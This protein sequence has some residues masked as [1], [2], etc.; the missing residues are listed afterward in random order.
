M[1]AMTLL[2]E[3][4]A[5]RPALLRVLL[6]LG[7][8]LSIPLI[9][10]PMPLPAQMVVSFGAV[11]LLLVLSR[12]AGRRWSLLMMAVSALL[13]SRYLWWR[14]TETMGMA[15][16][17]QTLLGIGLLLAE[18][19]AWVVMLLG[20]V[21]SA[22]P[23]G[24]K[25]VPLPAD[26]AA[27][28]HVDV[29]I[30]TYNESLEIVRNTVWAALDMDWP[31]DRLHVHLLDDGDRPEF[32]EFAARCGVNYIARP[33][34]RHAKAGNLNH[35]LAQT[36]APFIAIFDCDHVPNRAFL[37]MTM[38]GFLNEQRLALVQ[39]PHHFY[40]PDPV[41]RNLKPG[42]RLA[43]EGLLFY[44]LVQDGNDLWDSAFFCGSCAVLRREALVDIGGFAV[45][46]VTED[47]H[48]A[49]RLHRHGWTSAYLRLPLA[50]GLATETLSAHL[51]QRA[52]WARG[53][54]QIFRTDNP[55]FGR[56][57][58]WGQ[59]LCYLNAMLHFFFP[60][61]RIVVLTAPLA[62]LVLNINIMV[63]SAV[64]VVGYAGPHL[65]M[66]VATNHRLQG[67]Y[68]SLF[69]GEVYE[70][71]LAFHLLIPTLVTLINPKKGRFNVTD[72]GGL[73]GFGFFDRRSVLPQIVTILL[74]LA[75]YGWGI[76]RAATD[77]LAE[78]ELGVLLINMFWA[79]FNIMILG[80]AAATGLEKRQA[81]RHVRIG[82]RLPLTLHLPD[83]RQVQGVANDISMGGANLC[84]PMKQ[85]PAPAGTE[86]K[87]ELNL[88]GRPLL[89]PAQVM[90]DATN[91]TRLRF[92]D[93][94]EMHL[95]L[96]VLATFGRAD[97]WLDWDQVEEAGP[98]RSLRRILSS[99]I[100]LFAHWLR[101]PTGR[102][103]AAMLAGLGLLT[104][105]AVLPPAALAA[106]AADPLATA[107][108]RQEV[109]PLSGMAP[110][111]ALTLRGVL[112]RRGLDFTVR[113][114]EVV[115]AAA[116]R[117]SLGNSPALLS[118]LSHLQ[119]SVNG[120]MVGNVAFSP[121]TAEGQV[122]EIPIDPMVLR[123]ENRIGLEFVGHYTNGCE[124]P[125]H[126]SLWAMVNANS[127]LRLSL[128]RLALTTD[129]SLLPRPF[130]D[131]HDRRALNLPFVLGA[132]PSDAVLRAAGI[133]ASWFGAA[134]DFRPAHFPAYGDQLPDDH[135]VIVAM[136]Q[137]L[138]PG[139]D[140]GPVE[141]PTIAVIPNPLSP[142]HRLLLVLGRT[143]EE[144]TAAALALALGGAGGLTGE[145]ATV[146]APVPSAR[147]PYDAPR[148]IPTGRSVR[149][150]ELATP[151]QLQGQGLR[152][153]PVRISF[154]MAPDLFVWRGRGVPLTV[155]YRYPG[156]N[157]LDLAQSRLDI[158]LNGVYV[159][160]LKLREDRLT[161][162]FRTEL[163]DDY[164]RRERPVRLPPYLFY[165][166]NRLE[167]F[168]NLYPVNRGECQPTIPDNLR[169]VIDPDTEIDLSNVAH[170]T[171]LPNLSLLAGAGF[172][173]TRMADLGETLLLLPE[174]PQAADVEA[175]LDFLGLAGAATG[176]PVTRVQFRRGTV[177]DSVLRDRDLVLIGDFARQPLL[178]RWADRAPAR[179]QG[180]AVALNTISP[181]ERISSAL[182]D[183]PVAAGN[184][185]RQEAERALVDQTGDLGILMSFQSP[186][187]AG[188]TVV[189]VTG[190]SPALLP[191]LVGALRQPTQAEKVQGDLV[192]LNGGEL[193]SFQLGP[194][195]WVGQLDPWTQALWFASRHWPLVLLAALLGVA[196]FTLT[197]S[198]L[199][200]R[201]ARRR[202]AASAGREKQ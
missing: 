140:A 29:M 103:S 3:R 66:A 5:D 42:R 91:A 16:G 54:N 108:S 194:R 185:T 110:E 138:P 4:W 143:E 191:R 177:S 133:V 15:D 129:L 101:R 14:I 97:A 27:W 163:L 175:A 61:P 90:A 113:R 41:Q 72:K 43:N 168:Y 53:M 64:M 81:R 6:L 105:M 1:K 150:S 197:A 159:D 100:D 182:N 118:P 19:Y 174:Q 8:L 10:V 59:R 74:L 121:Q 187:T 2:F 127:A 126:S 161:D 89:L 86:I 158:S 69:W 11:A 176:Y 124:D 95:R 7:L 201:R 84:L 192:I 154:A 136:P 104:L 45:E 68:R 34:N 28:P 60:L 125:Q 37:Q 51:G 98:M 65:L 149:L 94:D 106:G 32:R 30:P 26:L 116:L 107:N 18:I 12:R 189:A 48:T 141:G 31:R 99:A 119:V 184:G 83:G 164:Q 47:A 85:P 152:P 38:G 56:G 188:R 147:Q 114:D 155:R 9:A 77:G 122:V 178:Q 170:F 17:T 70:T 96:L 146:R 55:L 198:V 79:W 190:T 162:W 80:A 73:L 196:L 115:T 63:A 139:L 183:D 173:Y 151:S 117:L 75:G 88:R 20:Y 39:T 156:G 199:L 23:L 78:G 130:F 82:L 58:N 202:L 71:I 172:P 49:L 153:G 145:R 200:R 128:Q 166:R 21:Q 112:D 40:S 52:R 135:G 57:L 144:M 148:W 36:E 132:N 50:A 35:A 76:F 171:T 157:W 109:L 134:A 25:P 46:T 160:S 179:P 44:G 24:R 33:D 93:L 165:G 62:Y 169:T 131:D 142:N 180:G 111:G 22:W 67:R 137:T 193:R 102:A 123:Q 13:S 120:E 92:A 167:L 87:V 181:L 186:V 195:Y